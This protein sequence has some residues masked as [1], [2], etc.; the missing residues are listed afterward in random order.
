MRE[1][2]RVRAAGDQA[3][4]MRH[5]DHQEGADLVGDGAELGEVDGARIGAA[6]RHDHLRLVLAGQGCDLV[7]VDA[8]VLPAH[9]VGHHLE[10][11]A[12]HV[13]GRPVRQMSAGGEA[14]SHEG[15]A[16][17]HHRHERGLVG[18]AARVRLHVGEAAAEQLL[19]A[20]DGEVLGLVDVLAAAVV[21]VA[22]IA[23]GVLVGEHA[24]R[25]LEHG[26]RDDILRG[27]QLDL[28]LLAAE[29]ALHATEQLGIAL[30]QA[31]RE[32]VGLWRGGA[33][34]GSGRH[35]KPVWFGRA[36]MARGPHIMGLAGATSRA[37]CSNHNCARQRRAF[38]LERGIIGV[39]RAATRHAHIVFCRVK[40]HI[41]AAG[42]PHAGVRL[43]YCDD[44]AIWP[45][46]L[47]QSELPG[48]ACGPF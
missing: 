8:V 11:L 40:A 28:V 39:C 44:L 20:L 2:A 3:R 31:S 23:F 22:G 32:Q 38:G 25:R 6:S 21:A 4:E 33:P 26:A 27:D 46:C 15:I 1:R 14:Q 29:L 9:G 16:G 18:G 35:G 41:A 36:Q 17:A 24:A 30:G 45:V 34:G 42:A 48:R 7:H 37:D 19:G 12:R 10:P 5:V 13:D 47:S 43:K